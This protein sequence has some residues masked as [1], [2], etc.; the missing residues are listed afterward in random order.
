MATPGIT[1]SDIAGICPHKSTYADVLCLHGIGYEVELIPPRQ[2]KNRIYPGKRVLVYRQ[3]CLRVVFIDVDGDLPASAMVTVVGVNEG[4]PLR[5]SDGLTPGM[6]IAKAERIIA[7]SY[8]EHS[9]CTSSV[10]IIPADGSGETMLGLYPDDGI[11]AF[12]GLYRRC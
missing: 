1:F 4:S 2:G 10:E 11:I 8:K 3:R 6:P 12:I 5:T 9:R 7:R